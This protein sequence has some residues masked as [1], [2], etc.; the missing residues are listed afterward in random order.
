MRTTNIS[1]SLPAFVVVFVLVFALVPACSGMAVGAVVSRLFPT[2]LLK[3][4]LT[5]KDYNA[6]MTLK[7]LFEATL[8]Q[9]IAIDLVSAYPSQR[10]LLA[11]YQIVFE[12][13]KLMKPKDSELTLHIS[14]DDSES[15]DGGHDVYG[16]KA[17]N[18]DERWGL[19][20]ASWAEWLGMR[21][22]PET[23]ST[24][25]PGQIAALSLFEMTFFGFT[26]DMREQENQKLMESAEEAQQHPERLHKFDMNEF[27]H[28]FTMKERLTDMNRW[29]RWGNISKEYFGENA[30]W[31]SEHFIGEN[32]PATYDE[33][34]RQTLK[35]ALKE[36]AN[37]ILYVAKEL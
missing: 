17:D 29:L 2:S 33:I 13:L 1:A 14:Y 30:Q 19:I 8:W 10:K 36:I 35:S 26:E 7:E 9:D 5:T 34:D 20:F 27:K 6:I 25:T 18:P 4:Q 21:L 16:T 28:E 22:A 23:I 37:Q 15:E 11:G 3:E 24:A 32:A 31:F 12:T